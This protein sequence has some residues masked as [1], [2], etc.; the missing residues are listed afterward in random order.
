MDYKYKSCING[1]LY[2]ADPDQDLNLQKKGPWKKRALALYQN[3]LYE[4]ETHFQQI[5]GC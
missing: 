2:K 5:R 1:I 3:S 4:L